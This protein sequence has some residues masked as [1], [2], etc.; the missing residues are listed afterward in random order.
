MSRTPW[1]GL[2]FGKLPPIDPAWRPRVDR[3]DLATCG[4]CEQARGYGWV[5]SNRTVACYACHR[6]AE[7]AGQPV[8][9]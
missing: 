5:G 4:I 9:T 7:K 2:D 3:A 8:F 1:A 6:D